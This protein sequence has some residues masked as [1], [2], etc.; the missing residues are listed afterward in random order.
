MQLKKYQLDW[1]G[2]QFGVLLEI[3]RF[4]RWHDIVPCGPAALAKRDDMVLR[5]EV[6]FALFRPAV[7]AT[8]LVGGFDVFPF[9]R[10]QSSW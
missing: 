8:M 5:Q 1:L 7:G 2:R 4:A 3:A 10:S 9:L 6:L